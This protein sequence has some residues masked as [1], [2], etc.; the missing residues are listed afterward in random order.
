MIDVGTVIA[1]GNTGCGRVGGGFTSIEYSVAVYPCGS[2]TGVPPDGRAATGVHA[3]PGVCMVART[4]NVNVPAACGV[5]VR[6]SVLVSMPSAF[7]S[8]SR[9]SATSS[10]AVVGWQS[11][12]T[13]G[14]PGAMR[15]NPG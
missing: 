12:P 6:A 11:L 9:Y 10:V 7:Q 1:A 2:T 5:T 15:P 8:S 3:P 4:R 14:E 13:M